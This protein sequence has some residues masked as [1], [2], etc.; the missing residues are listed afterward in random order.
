MNA[1]VFFEITKMQTAFHFASIQ[2]AILLWSPTQ[3]FYLVILL[4]H[5]IPTRNAMQHPEGLQQIPRALLLIHNTQPTMTPGES[6]KGE[7]GVHFVFEL[8]QRGISSWPY[9]VMTGLI[10]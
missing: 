6:G 5:C 7:G 3:G 2:A 10:N 9:T 1:D 8:E 4:F